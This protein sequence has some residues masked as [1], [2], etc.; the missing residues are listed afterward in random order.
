MEAKGRRALGN[1]G[2]RLCEISEQ[3]GKS[4]WPRFSGAENFA[5]VK[6]L[7]NRW[8]R[9]PLRIRGMVLRCIGQSPAQ[10][11]ACMAKTRKIEPTGRRGGLMPWPMIQGELLVV[12]NGDIGYARAPTPEV[13][14]EFWS[15]AV[16]KRP[17]ALFHEPTFVEHDENGG[18]TRS[19]WIH[20]SGPRTRPLTT[21]VG[22]LL[23]GGWVFPPTSNICLFKFCHSQIA[24]IT[25][26]T[27]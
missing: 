15:F 16:R 17:W 13:L 25:N 12:F 5:K 20:Q 14:K 22:H 6:R 26:I 21:M 19:T 8:R 9:T 2:I 11:W 10:I 24:S 27:F 4:G 3:M 1:P 23:R 18:R 7:Q